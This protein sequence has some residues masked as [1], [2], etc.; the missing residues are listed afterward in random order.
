MEWLILLIVIVFFVFIASASLKKKGA[1]SEDLPYTLN[2]QLFSPAERSFYG[3]LNQAVKHDA[4]VLGKVRV[5]D[6]LSPSEGLGRSSWQKAFNRIASKHFDY[7]ICAPDTLS[8]LAV[9][10]LDDRSHAKGSRAERDRFLDAAC[11]AAGVDLHRFP[12]AASYR[13]SEVR[14]VLFPPPADENAQVPGESEAC[15]VDDVE[16]ARCPKCS[17]ALV[18]KVAKKGEHK[19][20][21]FLACSAFPKCRYATKLDVEAPENAPAH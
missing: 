10:E 6:I 20:A 17:S 8:V 11:A 15:S 13:I 21:E 16:I 4:V 1:D 19:G 5:A 14:N 12:A 9:V 2:K 3:I 7:V 18:R